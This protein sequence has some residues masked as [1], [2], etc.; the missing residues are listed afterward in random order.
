M[1]GR[2]VES[3]AEAGLEEEAMVVAETVAVE[4]VMVV[5][6]AGRGS[7]SPSRANAA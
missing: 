3:E 1:E 7:R 6:M 4:M 5:S 2:A